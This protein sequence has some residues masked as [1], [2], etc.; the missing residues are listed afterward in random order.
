MENPTKPKYLTIF[1]IA[2]L[3][4]AGGYY[5]Y[6]DISKL[7]SPVVEPATETITKDGITFTAPKGS[8][9]KIEQVSDKPAKI[10]ALSLGRKIVPPANMPKDAQI[11]YAKKI[12][13]LEAKLQNNPDSFDDWITLGGLRSAIE[14]YTE[15]GRVWEFVSKNWPS[16][17]LSFSNLGDLYGYYIKD[18]QKAEENFLK[19]IQNGP[20]IEQIYIQT[21]NFYK[22]VMKD[23]AKARAILQKGK[24][25]IPSSLEIPKMLNALMP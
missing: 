13:E 22:D 6:Q 5:I 18:F 4:L 8:D 20:S 10:T 12:S 19:A 11:L 1:I 21:A 16:N 17:Y 15:A 24:T 7:S 3:L 23:V 2:V 14:D 25:A 9:I